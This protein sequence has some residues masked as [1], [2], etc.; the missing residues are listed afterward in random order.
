M[1]AGLR[2]GGKLWSLCHFD[3]VISRTM[4][5]PGTNN[6]L[7]SYLFIPMSFTYCAA[8]SRDIA[9]ALPLSIRE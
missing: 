3:C 4:T 1:R 6:P 7:N 9:V 8:L 5:A 2:E